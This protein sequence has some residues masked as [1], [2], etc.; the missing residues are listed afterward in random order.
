MENKL[1]EVKATAMTAEQQEAYQLHSQIMA[2]GNLAAQALV[3]M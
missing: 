1:T 3:D 2:S